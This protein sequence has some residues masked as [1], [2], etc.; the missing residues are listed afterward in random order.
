MDGVI[1]GRIVHFML[2]AQDA[3]EINK[4]RAQVD[5]SNVPQ[6]GTQMHVGNHVEAG[7]HIPMIIVKVWNKELGYVNGKLFL[8]GNDDFWVTSVSP[9]NEPHSWHWIEQT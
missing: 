9:G 7:E 6:N 8:D 3:A 4:K 1:E 5:W 2:S